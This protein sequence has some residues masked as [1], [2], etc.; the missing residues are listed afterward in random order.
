MD[1]I[2]NSQ[3]DLLSKSQEFRLDNVIFQ[4]IHLVGYFITTPSSASG[5]PR[6]FVTNQSIFDWI[7][8]NN[9]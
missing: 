2:W 1:I 4:F 5:I 7:C 8:G 3:L 6:H 9:C